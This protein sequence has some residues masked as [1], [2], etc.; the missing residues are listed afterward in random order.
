[1][2]RHVTCFIKCKEKFRNLLSV[3]NRKELLE[4]ERRDEREIKGEEER[5]KKEK[6]FTDSRIYLYRRK[7]E[8]RYQ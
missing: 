6:A 2:L 4:Q 5:E 1:M 8:V 7:V 3:P